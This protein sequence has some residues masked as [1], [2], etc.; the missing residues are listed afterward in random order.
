MRLTQIDKIR[1]EV[2][3]DLEDKYKRV[4]TQ[5]TNWGIINEAMYIAIKKTEYKIKE[6]EKE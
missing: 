1:A 5:F 6:G 2:W 4:E 3:K